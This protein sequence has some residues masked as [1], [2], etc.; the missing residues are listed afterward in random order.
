M[1]SRALAGLI[2]GLRRS[3]FGPEMKA[4]AAVLCN[5]AEPGPSRLRQVKKELMLLPGA[6]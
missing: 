3:L 6:P 5:G 1:T 4:T 2:R